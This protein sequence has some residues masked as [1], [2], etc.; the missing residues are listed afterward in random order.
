[1]SIWTRNRGGTGTWC[2]AH[3]VSS[4]GSV[5]AEPGRSLGQLGNICGVSRNSGPTPPRHI[6]CFFALLRRRTDPQSSRALSA[7]SVHAVVRWGSGSGPPNHRPNHRPASPPQPTFVRSARLAEKLSPG[8][9]ATPV[10]EPQPS[11][12]AP[13]RLRSAWSRTGTAVLPRFRCDPLSDRA[14]P[15]KVSETVNF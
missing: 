9:E 8:V 12:P 14:A 13:V 15:R 6:F 10:P 7:A 1:M 3:S 5:R 2:E 4:G 11:G